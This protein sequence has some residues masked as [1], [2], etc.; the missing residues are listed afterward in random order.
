MSVLDVHK[1][2]RALFCYY[3]EFDAEGLIEAFSV[4]DQ[5]PE[6]GIIKNFLSTRIQPSVFPSVLQARAG[7]VEPNP[8]PGNWHADIAEWAAALRTVRQAKE[9]YRVVELGCGW[10][11]WMTN[12]GVAARS[13]GLEIDLI[14]VEA[15]RYHL[16]SAE[17]T[18]RLNGFSTSQF[19]LHHG[20]AGPRSG[21]AAFPI[22]ENEGSHWGGKPIFDPTPDQLAQKDIQVLDSLTLED[23]SRGRPIDLLHID[24]QGGEYKYVL[25]SAEMIAKQVRRVLIGTHSRTIEGS[26]FSHFL[27]SGWRLEMERPAIAPPV[28]GR[29]KTRVD[30]VQ[31]WANP[32]T[33]R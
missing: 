16:S 2:Q 21:K 32:A 25:G 15:D 17:E 31:M 1:I 5:Q 28:K 10:G 7:T 4:P 12:M 9:T 23:M 24:I 19:T 26:L 14:G 20:V 30:G 27:K 18:L 8:N 22:H 29:P 33:I 6:E 3:C 13:Q 11:C